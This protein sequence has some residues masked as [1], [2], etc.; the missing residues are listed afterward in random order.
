M[1]IEIRTIERERTDDYL[2]AVSRGFLDPTIDDADLEM[3]RARFLE[4]RWWGALD[5]GAI[6]ATLRTLPLDTTLPG[7]RVITSCGVTAVTTTS[8]HRRRGLMAEMM[9]RA[10]HDGREAG[11]PLTTLIAA[12]WPIYGRFGFGAACE[13]ASYEIDAGRV[14][15]RREGAGTVS[16]V[17]ADEYL[18]AALA[19]YDRHRLASP[20]EIARDEFVWRMDALGMPSE[21]FKGFYVLCHDGRGEVTG[22]AQYKVDKHFDQ[23]RPASTVTVEELMGDP[24]AELALWRYVCGIDWTTRV[25]AHNRSVDERL[26]WWVV[27]GRHV[28]QTERADAVWARPLDVAAC[29]SA[30]SYSA[31]V[32]VVLDVVDPLKLSSGRFRLQASADGATCASTPD[33][34]D[35]TCGVATLG[36]VLFGGY[37]LATFARAGLVDEHRAGAVAAATA[38]LRADVTP[39][40]VTWF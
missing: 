15:F 12:E 14:R 25:V 34:A 7:R 2:R 1:G 10:L 33:G 40:S 35:I 28:R 9:T 19:V 21:P 26:P 24:D 22:Y 18:A 29:L 38:A 27:D 5:D 8:T 17:T 37:A 23:R 39:W 4:G 31:P 16:L 20:I 36:S 32:D 3:R 13:H 6:V 30:R 11:E